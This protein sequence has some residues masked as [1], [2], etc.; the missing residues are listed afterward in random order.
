MSLPTRLSEWP[1]YRMLWLQDA[2]GTGRRWPEM[3]WGMSRG[4]RGAHEETGPHLT[5]SRI[6]GAGS[7]FHRSSFSLELEHHVS[8][9]LRPFV[10]AKSP[11][12]SRPVSSSGS[13]PSHSLQRRQPQRAHVPHACT[14]GPVRVCSKQRWPCQAGSRHCG[15]EATS[16]LC[17]GRERT[18]ECVCV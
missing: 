2:C 10:W 3:Y 6:V 13:P 5:A 17:H 15:L 9:S 11:L 14:G 16:A 4:W 8:P 1:G 12:G 18:S 7:S